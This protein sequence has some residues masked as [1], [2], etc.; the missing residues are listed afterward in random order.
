MIRNPLEQQ[1][2]PQVK[3]FLLA[4][5]ILVGTGWIGLFL[6]IFLTLPTVGP[7]WLFFFFSVLAV[8]GMALP[9]VAFLN[10]RFPSKPPIS[11]KV[12]VRQA[13][14]VGIYV[15]TLAWLQIGRVLTPAMALLLAGGFI[16]IELL[17]RLRERSQ[18]KPQGPVA[19]PPAQDRPSGHG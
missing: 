10:V 14:W 1:Q 6:V 16:M 3:D 19:E 8:T 5:E 18:W 13:I 7:R 12:V 9:G 2:N 4:A 17:L 15:P 11:P